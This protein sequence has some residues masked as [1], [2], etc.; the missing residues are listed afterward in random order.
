MTNLKGNFSVCLGS[1]DALKKQLNGEVVDL[2]VC[3][4]L[5]SVIEEMAPSFHDLLP[6]GGRVFLSGLLNDEVSRLSGIFA[7]LNWDIK[8]S[9]EKENWAL[10]EICKK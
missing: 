9:R 3:N 5:A 8:S 4:I 6:S 1:V 2:M 7:S 10:L